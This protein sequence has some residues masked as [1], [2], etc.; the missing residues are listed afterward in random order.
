[1]CEVLVVGVIAQE[2]VERRKGTP[3]MSLKERWALVESCKWADEIVLA[4]TYDPTLEDLERNNCSHIAHGDDM[5]VGP[6][7]E[8]VYDV[9]KKSNRMKVYRRTEGISTTDIVGRLLLMST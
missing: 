2:E 8:D 6:N 1:M 4:P 5:I 7:G 9:F 3:V